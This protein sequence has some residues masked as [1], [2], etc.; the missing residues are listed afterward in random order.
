MALTRDQKVAQVKDLT[1]KM[2]KA[3]SI[4]FTNYLGLTVAQITKLRSELRKGGAEMKVAK[5]NLIQIAAKEA[6]APEVTDEMLPGDIACVFSYEE[7]TA[8]PSVTHKFAKDHPFVKLVG[9]IFDGKTLSKTE[10][11]S[12]ATIPSRQQLL[13][14]FAGMIQS[15]ISSFARSIGSPLTSFARAM[16]EYSKKAPTA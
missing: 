1:Q 5:K 9:G 16:S 10:A 14:I 15:P 2:A 6:N 3:T 12:L 4:V 13:G 7:P 8:G 11:V